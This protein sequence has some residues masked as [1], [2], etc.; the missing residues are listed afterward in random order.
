MQ[1]TSDE[2]PFLNYVFVASLYCKN[3]FVNKI[4]VLVFKWFFHLFCFVL[5][6]LFFRMILTEQCR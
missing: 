4:V 1:A 3:K 2:K 5:F 6:C